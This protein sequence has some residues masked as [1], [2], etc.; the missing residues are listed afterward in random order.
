MLPSLSKISP[1]QDQSD[2][3]PSA[4][5]WFVRFYRASQ[6]FFLPPLLTS[7]L[8]TIVLLN[9]PILPS[10]TEVDLSL[11]DI[12]SFAH[13]HGL[14]FGPD[15]TSTYG[16]LSWLYFPYFSPHSGTTHLLVDFALT[17]LALGGFCIAAWRLKLL[18]RIILLIGF[19]WGAANVS[20]RGDLLINTGLLCWGLL[21]VLE[22]GSC[23]TVPI[24]AFVALAVYAS[25]AKVSF[26]FTAGMS[27][28]T[29]TCDLWLRGV[30]RPAFGLLL[31]FGAGLL[32]V[33]LAT[34]QSIF[35]FGI[36]LSHALLTAQSYNQALGIE[37]LIVL[38]QYAFALAIILLA[39]LA[40]RLV[41]AFEPQS[42]YVRLR[43]GLLFL[44]LSFLA[45]TNWKHGFT[46]LDSF[47]SSLF[48]NFALVMALASD[49]LPANNAIV[50]SGANG[51]ALLCSF[52]AIFLLQMFF[53]LPLPVSLAMPLSQLKIHLGD[54]LHP[55]QYERS[56]EELRAAIHRDYMLPKFRQIIGQSPVDVFGQYQSYVLENQLQYRPRPVSQSYNSCNRALM[57]L[58]ESFYLSSDA[59]RFV[60]FDIKAMDD[61][62]PPLEDAWLLRHLLI[63]FQPVARENRFVL[64]KAKS[65]Q[66]STLTLLREGSVSFG[67]TVNL[68][69]YGDGPFWL[70]ME[71]TPTWRGW[72]RQFFYASPVIR[73]AAW[74]DLGKTNIIKRRAPA[75]MLAAGFLASPLLLRTFDIEQL[76]NDPKNARCP[77]AYSVDAAPGQQSLWSDQIRFRLYR[78]ENPIGGSSREISAFNLFRNTRWHPTRDSSNLNLDRF[79]FAVLFSLPCL[80]AFGFVLFYRRTRRSGFISW[81]RLLVGNSLMLLFFVS[82][83]LLGGEIRFRFFYDTTDSLGFTKVCE[84]WISRHW[85]TNAAGCRDNLEYSPQ[86]QPGKRRVTFIGDSFTA[87][88]GIKDVDARFSN[89]IRALHPQWEVHVLANVGLDTGDELKLL[90]KALSKGYQLDQVVLVYCL[91]DLGDLL[92]GP[93]GPFE[94][95]LPNADVRGPWFTQGS[96]FLDLLYNRYQA[97]RNPY[98]KDYFSYVKAG[99]RDKFWEKQ[100]ERLKEFRDLVESH[101]GHL[102]AVT[103]PFLHALGPNYDYQFAHVELDAFWRELHV[104]HL[105]LL[106]TY[107]SLPAQALTVNRFDAHPNEYANQLAAAAIN[108]FLS[109]EIRATSPGTTPTSGPQ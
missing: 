29:I 93:G 40:T 56:L 34:G 45:F 17:L 100:K 15:I 50:R 44:W 84:R 79:T 65:A 48:L 21:C 51:L 46:R 85:R 14:Q 23:L 64:L 30:Y 87:G 8:L 33:W 36:F 5:A 18:W 9:I 2:Q 49:V 101:G 83:V 4:R 43:R 75:S 25:L 10:S 24:V 27:V 97:A 66:P 42:R 107:Q 102:S 72:L 55:T 13:E 81:P 69:E 16:P 41:V 90:K 60:L 59:P 86:L 77:A 32:V 103:F 91:N 96:Y 58:N 80:C 47:H 73:L 11:G 53:F 68:Q 22:S 71:L 20:F 82:T 94:G 95:S 99:Y 52:G 12:L 6:R 35:N 105:D 78:I 63:N 37:G 26:L 98:V 108:D 109:P 3:P 38:R 88:H 57:A 74:S 62:F 54:L 92:A 39:L 70:E 106:S 67:Q 104:P 19:C 61:K 76:F 89:R 1:P 28:A 31:G 7:L